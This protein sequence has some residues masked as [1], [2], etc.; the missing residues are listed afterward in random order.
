MHSAE[1][2]R[3]GRTC[4][5][6]CWLFFFQAEDGIRDSSVTG[7]Q[8]CALPIYAT[9]AFTSNNAVCLN[10]DDQ[11]PRRDIV[12]RKCQRSIP[13]I[14]GPLDWHRRFHAELDPALDRKSV[15]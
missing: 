10:F 15:V 4:T 1:V 3:D 14:E 11:K 9:L 7:V 8:T 5:I 12:G 13:L 2:C 6:V